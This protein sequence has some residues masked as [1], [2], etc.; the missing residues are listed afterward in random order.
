MTP[1]YKPFTTLC[2]VCLFGKQTNTEKIVSELKRSTSKFTYIW[3]LFRIRINYLLVNLAVADIVFATFHI[4]ELVYNHIGTHPDGAAGKAVC[5]L[6]NGTLQWIGAAASVFTV[7]AIAVERY[8]AVIHP[9]GNKG[10]LTMQK[11]KVCHFRFPFL[12]CRLPESSR[13]KSK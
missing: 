3:F 6:R 8:F 11:V 13:S 4:T 5:I 2:Y 1:G 9:H 12:G 7:V 10:H